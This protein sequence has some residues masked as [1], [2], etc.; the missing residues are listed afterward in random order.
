[1][2]MRRREHM[3]NAA[4]DVL[5]RYEKLYAHMR[6]IGIASFFLIPVHTVRVDGHI[7]EARFIRI[8][9]LD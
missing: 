7:E 8:L 6:K 2:A 1:M 9:H 4:I 3:S 5:L